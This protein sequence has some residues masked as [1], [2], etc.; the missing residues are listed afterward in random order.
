MSSSSMLEA[1]LKG[2]LTALVPG[3]HPMLFGDDDPFFLGVMYGVFTGTGIV[4]AR[5][6]I[7][8]PETAGEDPYTFRDVLIGM[9]AGLALVP[10]AV[11]LYS[12]RMPRS[13]LF[14]VL[15]LASLPLMKYPLPFLLSG[16][17]GVVILREPVAVTL[18]LASGLFYI[19]GSRVLFGREVKERRGDWRR[20]VVASLL[21]GYFPA[22]PPS[23][24]AHLLRGGSV[25]VAAALTPLFSLVSLL[26]W[27]T[28]AVLTS[29]IS[30]PY[31]EI[32]LLIGTAYTL[33]LLLVI[34]LGEVLEVERLVLPKEVLLGIMVAHALYLGVGNVLLLISSLALGYLSRNSPPSSLFGFLIIPTLAYYS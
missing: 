3:L 6:G 30:Y 1:A 28:R 16:L 32:L 9:L 29:F 17:V 24:W 11:A 4:L 15:L 5:K 10:V 13:V 7:F 26:Y 12:L 31:P 21:T 23:A 33:S 2:F 27:R 18:P 19:F 25:A 8:H 22:L 34:S 14:P 20:G